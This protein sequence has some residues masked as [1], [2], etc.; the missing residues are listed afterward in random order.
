MSG[1]VNGALELELGA[2]LRGTRL[3][4]EEAEGIGLD[5]APGK[6]LAIAAGSSLSQRLVGYPGV[7][8]V[9]GRSIATTGSRFMGTIFATL[10]SLSLQSPAE[11]VLGPV[12]LLG[13][14][15]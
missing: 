10:W 4:S 11:E 9:A 2:P 3:D 1:L 6:G 15:G 7:V 14:T 13:R 12:E 5:E 8:L